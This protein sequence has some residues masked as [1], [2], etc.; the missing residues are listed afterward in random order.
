[1]ST[2]DVDSSDR[3]ET[4]TDSDGTDDGDHDSDGIDDGD[5]DADAAA[6]LERTAARAELL[7]E[8][9]HRLRNEYARARQSRYRRAA[10]GLGAIGLFA[11]AAGLVFPASREVLFALGATGLFGGLLTHYLT[12][13][14]FVAASVGERV[15]AAWAAN[16]AAIAAELGLRE[17]RVYLPD[18]GTETARLYVP[19]HA[20]YDAPT[21]LEGPIALEEGER[22]LVLTPTGATLFEEFRRALPGDLASRPGPLAAQLCD[23]LVEQFEL[24]DRADPDVDAADG[25]VTVAISG[26]A[27]GAVDRFDHPIGS[28]V[29]VGLAVG[30]E[31]DVRL[32]VEPG[33]DRADW[34]VTC[35]FETSE[36]GQ[37]D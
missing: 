31:R 14:Q 21:D 24:A 2:N 37:T 18:A 17:E 25:R 6:R 19:L 28:F 33:D 26:S 29:A 4:V 11:V 20:A 34:L 16:G 22:G 8:E 30:L 13:G 27:F 35:R 36:S 9:N 23:A 7:A 3:T 5:S 10:L 1:M 32:E 15:Y 12:P